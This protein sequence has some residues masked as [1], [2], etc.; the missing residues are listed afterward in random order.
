MQINGGRMDKFAA[1]SDAAGL[2]MGY[3][4]MSAQP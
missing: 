3:F 1:I 4:D 2:S